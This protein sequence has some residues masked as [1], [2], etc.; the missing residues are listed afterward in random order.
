M[1]LHITQDTRIPLQRLLPVALV[2]VC[3]I[4]PEFA[5]CSSSWASFSGLAL[6]IALVPLSAPWS[7]CRKGALGCRFKPAVRTTH[8]QIPIQN[9]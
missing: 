4:D 9:T 7:L 1:T 8:P 3:P 6:V 2:F 5:F